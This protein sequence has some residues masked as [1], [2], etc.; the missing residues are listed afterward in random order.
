MI[1]QKRVLV[2]AGPT[3]VG[4]STIT[5]KIIKQYPI[6]KRLITATTREPRLNEKNRKDYYFFSADRFK[7]EIKKGNIIEH[8]FIKNRNVYYGSYKYD[9]ENKLKKG[10]NIIVNT[11]IVG[12]KY[13]KKNYNAATIFI[14]P[15]SLANLKKRQLFR[16]KNISKDELRKRMNY[17]KQEINNEA[18][19]Y[20]YTVI[21]KQDEL[22]SA[23]KK[24]I[25][26]IKTEGY[27]LK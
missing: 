19:F 17:A 9:L 14:K 20:S 16:N 2:I 21:N 8:T 15:D 3:G 1:Q 24:V 26:I 18:P 12:A 4:E 6:F 11:D 25:K 22:N 23:M 10:H 7:D 5:K 27:C 13:Y